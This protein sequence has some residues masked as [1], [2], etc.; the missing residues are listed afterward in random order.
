MYVVNAYFPEK[1]Y[2]VIEVIFLDDFCFLSL[3]TGDCFG[4]PYLY[5]E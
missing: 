4:L 3:A 2:F 5:T 1:K